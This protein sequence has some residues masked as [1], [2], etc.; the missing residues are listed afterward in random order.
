MKMTVKTL[1]GLTGGL[2]KPSKMPCH[3]YSIPA[4]HCKIGQKMRKVAGSICSVCYA[5]KG[6]YVFPSV[7]EALDRR[8][9]SMKNANWANLMSALIAKQEKSGFFRWH[10]SGDL[11]SAKHLED[12]VQIA[13][14]L[15]DVCFWLPSRE[16]NTVNEFVLKNSI[17]K[18]LTIRLSALM[19]NGKV[20]ER[21]NPHG[22]PTS[23]AGADGF[24]C[25]SSRQGNKCLNCRACWD[26]A[27]PNITYKKQ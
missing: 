19:L 11:Q 17:P 22:L 10:D 18:N 5:L 6:R 27:E 25:P 24:N 12:I 9:E 21:Q 3:G 20:T 2:S 13:R 4:R 15:P 1:H 23:S 8:Y 16:F 7:Q 14:N 26:K